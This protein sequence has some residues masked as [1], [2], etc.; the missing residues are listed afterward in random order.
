[1]VKTS[2]IAIA[3]AGPLIH[4]DELNSLDLLTDFGSIIVPNAVWHEVEHHRPHA[5]QHSEI[6]LIRKSVI[7]FGSVIVK[8][9]IF[10][11]SVFSTA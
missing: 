10:K 6:N 11:Y 5:L 7:N 9:G 3:D 8:C 4:L 1:M 2:I